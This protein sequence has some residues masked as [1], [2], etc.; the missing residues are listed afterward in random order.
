MPL[1]TVVLILVAVGVVV[2]LLKRHGG[3]IVD[4]PYLTWIVWL[5][6][7]AT[8]IWLLQIIGVFDYFRAVPMPSM[9][10]R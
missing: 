4:E 3:K 10:G 2:T 9:R 7:I 6:L 1:L 5:I 8:A